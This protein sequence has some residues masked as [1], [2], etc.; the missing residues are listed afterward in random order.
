MGNMEK[1][2]VIKNKHNQERRQHSS[3]GEASWR[4]DQEVRGGEAE[5][6][7]ELQH[8]CKVNLS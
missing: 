8:Q 5:E 2:K 6:R 4:E 1:G 7:V 3:K